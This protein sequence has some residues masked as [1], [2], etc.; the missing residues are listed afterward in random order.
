MYHYFNGNY[1][2]A[3][4]YYND[5]LAAAGE[6][7]FGDYPAYTLTRMGNLYRVQRSYDSADLYY[8]KSLELLKD[9]D[10]DFARSSVY[11]NLGWLSYELSKYNEAMRYLRQ[12]LTL[13]LQIGDSLLIAE[14]W[15]FMGTTHSAL[16]NFDSA[17][18][19]FE[20]VNGL[21]ERYNDTELR[22]FYRVSMGEL[23]NTQGKI[24]DAIS[25]YEQALESL[26]KHK[27]KR[28]EAIT[29]KR[30]G[31][32]Y[33]QLGDYERAN[34]HFFQALEIEERL[35]SRHE[36]AR[37]YGL[38]SWCF[39]HQGN[40]IQGEHYVKK[41]LALMKQVKDR[42]GIAYAQNLYGTL[43]SSLRDFASALFFYDSALQIRKELGLI[44]YE[45]STL[46]N[47]AY[48]FE[49]KGDWQRSLDIHEQVL[50]IFKQTDSGSRMTTSLNNI[51]ELKY[52]LGN[53]REALNLVK[54][55]IESSQS[56]NL[57]LELK[58]AYLLA[59]KIHKSSGE[60]FKASDYLNKYIQI[61]DS[62]FSIESIAKAAQIHALYDLEKKEQQI[63]LLNRE[64]QIKANEIELQESKL[65]NQTWAL[66][67]SAVAGLLLLA[68]TI[69]LFNYYLNKKKANYRLQALNVQI[70]EKQEEIQRQAEELIET[71]S[72]LID[73]NHDLQ[74]KKN[75]VETK[76]EELREANEAIYLAN[77]NLERK[78]ADRTAELRQAYLELDT[79]F[80]RSSHD[81]RRPLTTFMG[82]AEVAKITLKDPNAIHLFEKV[83]ETAVNLDKMLLKLQS[84]SDVGVQQLAYKEVYF[85]ELINS[86]IVTYQYEIDKKGIQVI[87][88]IKKNELFSYPSLLKII[89]EN[90]LENAINFCAN[91]NPIITIS[92]RQEGTRFIFQIEDNGQ[93]IDAA[94]KERI[95]DMYYRASL[96]S[97]GNG[98]GLYIVKKA[99]DKLGGN[100][101][102]ESEVSKG[103]GFQID[104]PNQKQ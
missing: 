83:K 76:S 61:N 9:I 17:H 97:K 6:R 46:E 75:E 28:Y 87:V 7:N 5:A 79:F 64:N 23:Y 67:F 33:D 56:L 18:F 14:T 31:T 1:K 36:M 93:G 43:K 88:N 26:N 16:L 34:K 73:V 30:I 51:A 72:R 20:K 40:A 101:R 66:I 95:F 71:N 48:V 3:K 21:A 63:E 4:Q 82:L 89:I 69:T 70:S 54:A 55:S 91:V 19:Y 74:Q 52:K 86:I 10:A 45:A 77:T 27:F 47:T 100:I 13:R 103:T 65:K 38:I 49:A 62:L 39:Y 58:R 80:Y 90:L 94:Y 60:F 15:K 85:K 102:V 84:I 99:I 2:L 59:G 81:F 35:E 32:I 22:I 41:S 25:M 92:A 24:L 44:I 98:L 11:H 78:V 42:A 8:I 29:L 57:P 96:D 104:I 68:I 12:S 53:S 37:T 50:A